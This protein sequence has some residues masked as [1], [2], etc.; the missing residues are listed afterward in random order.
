MLNLSPSSYRNAGDVARTVNTKKVLPR[1]PWYAPHIDPSEIL[2]QQEQYLS[3]KVYEDDLRKTYW[4]S[5]HNLVS[6]LLAHSI[7]NL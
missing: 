7:R 1:R 4:G 2:R 5:A 3:G 6:N